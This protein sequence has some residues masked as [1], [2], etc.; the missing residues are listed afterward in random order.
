MA[1]L[2]LRVI[3]F[4]C[5][6]LSRFHDLPIIGLRE[7]TPVI[8]VMT[9]RPISD[10]AKTQVTAFIHEMRL[11]LSVEFEVVLPPSSNEPPPNRRSTFNDN[12]ALL[13]RPA[14]RRPSAPSFVRADEAFWFDHLSDAAT[15]LM[16]LERFPGIT[17]NRYRCYIDCTV[18]E[19]VNLRQA[20]LLYDEVFCS[21]PLA[22]EHGA[23]LAKQGLS[24]LDLLQVIE[25]KRLT[26]V[27]TQ[28]EERLWIL[29]LEAAA[30]RRP[31]A[32]LG[33]RAAALLLIA[34]VA[35]TADRY[36]LAD[37]KFYPALRELAEVIAPYLSLPPATLLRA[38][39][40]PLTARRQSLLGLMDRGTKAGPGL[41][42]A[43]VLA[44]VVKN[45]TKIDIALEAMVVS[46]R[47][48]LGHALN[49]TVFSAL[50][51]PASLTPLMTTLGREL[52]FYRSFNTTI[53]AAWAG[54]ER[55]RAEGV[56]IVPPIPLLEFDP[57]I[58][59]TEVLSDTALQSTRAKGRALFSRLAELPAE[60]RGAEIDAL[61]DR[62]RNAA[63][64]RE[65]TMLSF[66]NLDTA[67]SVGSL[68]ASFVY[69]PI[70]GLAKLT[71]PIA[72]RLRRIPSVDRMLQTVNED[73][74]AAFGRNQDLDF[75][76]R[77]SRVAQLKRPRI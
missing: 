13:I 10:E 74:V 67:I 44:D 2:P 25:A 53:A 48:H 30:E 15:G 55:R 9:D 69:P 64:R 34:D 31:H 40:W 24:E 19:H 20:L 37:A 73:T 59:M 14:R 54:N 28:P 38:L 21:L 47:V 8:Y 36:R 11:P 23:F 27:S 26:I 49:A 29:F 41:E 43:Q 17:P 71:R 1:G 52:N 57:K 18:G 75:L 35:Q 33:R 16:P 76:S 42:L 50:D 5:M 51:E 72:E 62:L 39:L 68:F 7:A 61:V 4:D 32:I 12:D 56:Q 70:A 22:E 63:R 66:D 46:E 45:A 6:V 58:P 65:N 77:I 60:A 3:D